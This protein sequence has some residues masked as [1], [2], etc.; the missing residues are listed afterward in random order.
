MITA[1]EAIPCRAAFGA[2]A[3]AWQRHPAAHFARFPRR[4][5]DSVLVVITDADGHHGIGEAWGL[6]A[7]GAAA[8]LIDDLLAPALIGR[9]VL[10]A[11]DDWDALHDHLQRLGHAEGSGLDALSGIDIALVDLLARRAGQPACRWLGGEPRVIAVYAAPVPLLPTPEASATHAAELIA[12]GHRGLKVKLGRGAEADAEHLSAIRHAVG[13]AVS[14]R[15]DANGG[16]GGDAAQAIATARALAPLDIAWLEDPVPPENLDA[17]RAV[18]A[19][20]P[21]AIAAGEQLH[22]PR[23]F[24]ALMASGGVDVVVPNISRVGGFEGL[25]RIAE[26]GAAAG[27]AVSAHG[28]GSAITQAATLHA[29]AAWLPEQVMEWNV[30]PSPLR[31]D[32][33][34]PLP[35][36][37]DGHA[38]PP[39]GPG[40]GL[41]TVASAVARHRTDHACLG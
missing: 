15:V 12:R 4:G 23:A 33:A 5:Q 3:P 18:R 34:A 40:L 16:G 8:A 11:R 37:R 17:L 35:T 26:A 38:A 39:A 27:V 29:M 25:R 31:D 41:D 22:S 2:D 13:P 28:V 20:S 30:F 9:R 32:L 1:I 6:P 14:L 36:C 7:P 10:D 19:A 21:I 24:A